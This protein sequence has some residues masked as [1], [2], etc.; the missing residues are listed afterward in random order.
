MFY[1]LC[2]NPR[3]YNAVV[4][5]IDKMD[6]AGE[7]STIV[8]FAEANRMPYL[9]AS[10]KE[11]MRIHPAVGQLLERV[12]PKGGA[13]IAGVWLPEGT[14]LGMN[15]WVPSRDRSVYGSDADEYRPERWMEADAETLKLME[16][17]FLAVSDVVRGL[18]LS[19]SN[20]DFS[21]K[22]G[23]GARTCLGKNVSLLE[24]SKLV[25]QILRDYVVELSDPE[26]DWT[27]SD[28]WFVKQTNL[29]CRL[30]RRGK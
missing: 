21:Q 13:T 10:M 27:L 8:T 2:K 14:I 26:A 11:A 6:R 23:S 18:L 20:A 24:M 25:P 19:R 4:Q 17:N 9:Q 22:F 30:R 28:R 1:Y 7:L 3:C 12:V 29:I 16:R 15:P 5:E